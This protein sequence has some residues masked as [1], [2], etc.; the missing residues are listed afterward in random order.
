[1]SDDR[2]PIADDRSPARFR[3]VVLTASLVGVVVFVLIR[4]LAP[5]MGSDCEV[6]SIGLLREPVN[7]LSALAIVA[8]GWVVSRQQVAAGSALVVAGAAS[9][10][11]HGS[12][13]AMARTLDGV[14]ALVALVV[15]CL[16]VVRIGPGRRRVVGAISVA[17]ASLV[18]WA[19]SRSAGP[20]CDA[21]GPSGHAGW[22]IGMA[23][24]A[25]IALDERPVASSQ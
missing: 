19:L 18:L 9:V 16:T 11:A 22:H 3:L 4:P 10:A 23:L 8:A 5:T 12:A 14:M 6:L 7:A 13:N 1:M 24:A 15:I 2:G 20:W 21:L 25:V 17:I